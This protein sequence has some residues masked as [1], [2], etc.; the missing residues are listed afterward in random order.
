MYFF[1]HLASYLQT[2]NHIN[3]WEWYIDPGPQLEY[4]YLWASQVVSD[5]IL[6]AMQET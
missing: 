6:L 4:L 5:K 1:S 3:F 2:E